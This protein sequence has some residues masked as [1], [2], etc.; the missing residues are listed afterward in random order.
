MRHSTLIAVLLAHS[1][2][3]SATSFTAREEQMT[4]A[5]PDDMHPEWPTR[6]SA[7][8]WHPLD[9]DSAQVTEQAACG[10]VCVLTPEVMEGPFYLDYHIKRDDI[11][12]NVQGIPLDL[13]FTVYDISSSLSDTSLSASQCRPLS[14]AW[15]DIWHCDVSGVYS[16]YGKAAEEPGHPGG[17]GPPPP[18]P[19]PGRPGKP[20]GGPDHPGGPGGPGGHAEPENNSTFLRGIQQ[21]D[22]QGRAT[23]RTVYPGWYPGRA[24]HV[25]LK[26]HPPSWA[27]ELDSDFA[28]QGLN[29]THTHTTQMF[30]PE[31]LNKLVESH[32]VF[33]NNSVKRVAN[34]QD[35]LYKQTEGVTVARAGLV[36]DDLAQGVWAELRIGI[37]RWW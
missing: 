26:V 19:P 35:M 6:Q 9:S 32:A 2:Q 20:P 36:G 13:S 12:E 10:G 23:F 33:A 25:H 30:L 28:G 27:A 5:V 15:V 22:S 3:A 37:D 7:L 16:G 17:G 24:I 18:G 31:Q 14:D 8:G 21:T 4:F 29:E 11:T 1:L 34:D